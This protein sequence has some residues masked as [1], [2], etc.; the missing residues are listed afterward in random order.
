MNYT[1]RKHQQLD[2]KSH[3]ET[4]EKQKLKKKLH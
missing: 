3:E 2:I 1:D 4:A